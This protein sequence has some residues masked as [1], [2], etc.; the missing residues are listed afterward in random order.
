MIVSIN[1]P[2]YFY[3][4]P[5]SEIIMRAV[6]HS[7]P[8]TGKVQNTWEA[9]VKDFDNELEVLMDAPTSKIR[10]VAGDMVADAVQAFRDGKIQIIGQ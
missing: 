4:I 6:G 5:L 3:L 2:E 7:S 8:F 1:N 9:L 10:K